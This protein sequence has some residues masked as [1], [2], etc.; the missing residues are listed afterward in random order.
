MIPRPKADINPEA[1]SASGLFPAPDLG[2]GR[3]KPYSS[4]GQAPKMI[5]LTGRLRTGTPAGTEHASTP[6]R[7]C[8]ANTGVY[9]TLDF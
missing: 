5:P 7:G 6:F 3:K 4:D 2:E 8:K 1:R 9:N